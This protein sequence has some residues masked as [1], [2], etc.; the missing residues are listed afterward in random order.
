MLYTCSMFQCLFILVLNIF[1]FCFCLSVSILCVCFL[2]LRTERGRGSR[3]FI[4]Y[5]NKLPH[6]F[7]C[8]FYIKLFPHFLNSRLAFVISRLRLKSIEKIAKQQCFALH[9]LVTLA[10]AV[11]VTFAVTHTRR[12]LARS[13]ARTQPVSTFAFFCLN[14]LSLSSIIGCTHAHIQLTCICF[15]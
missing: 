4:C 11:C 12:L 6:F 14:F 5:S 15:V 8:L 13:L 1:V 7:V 10:H 2:R 3:Q 9:N